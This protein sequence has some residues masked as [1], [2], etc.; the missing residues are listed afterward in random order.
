MC[1]RFQIHKQTSETFQRF[2][3]YRAEWFGKGPLGSHLSTLIVTGSPE[4]RRLPESI[5]SLEDLQTC[6]LSV[7]IETL[8][9]LSRLRRLRVLNL[10]GCMRL[11]SLDMHGLHALEVSSFSPSRW[12]LTGSEVC[13]TF[14]FQPWIRLS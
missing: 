7:G 8:P 9:N 4:L 13:V 10:D 5:G 6:H 1:R 2:A 3:I 11:A 12:L 14:Q